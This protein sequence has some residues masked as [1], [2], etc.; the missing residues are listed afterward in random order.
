[1]YDLVHRQ[2]QNLCYTFY[3]SKEIRGLDEEDNVSDTPLP[4]SI[5]VEGTSREIWFSGLRRMWETLTLVSERYISC[6]QK[7]EKG[8]ESGGKQ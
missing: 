2:K 7:R 6:Y 5:V 4:S 8:K 1:V 3:L